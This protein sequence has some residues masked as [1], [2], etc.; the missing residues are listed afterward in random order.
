MADQDWGRELTAHRIALIIIAAEAHPMRPVTD[1]DMG[2]EVDGKD[3]HIAYMDEFD[4]VRWQDHDLPHSTN[5][6]I[7]DSGNDGG[8][9]QVTI[10]QLL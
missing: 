2:Y 7:F 9:W 5:Y 10:T 6:Q 1:D 4:V 8:A 3:P